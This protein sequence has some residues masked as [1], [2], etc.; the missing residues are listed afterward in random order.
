MKTRYI[1]RI[2]N[3][4][5]NL[6]QNTR[7]HLV[8]TVGNGYPM[9]CVS[10]TVCTLC[11][12]VIW[13]NHR[14]LFIWLYISIQKKNAYYWAKNVFVAETRTR[15]FHFQAHSSTKQYYTILNTNQH[16]RWPQERQ[17]LPTPFCLLDT[18]HH[19][20]AYITQQTVVYTADNSTP[21]LNIKQFY[22]NYTAAFE[23][24]KYLDELPRTLK[25]T[26]ILPAYVQSCVCLY[27]CAFV[28]I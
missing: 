11:V 3:I 25:F 26:F 12:T 28:C 18:T 24:A 8:W 17:E 23:F 4:K 21:R 9:N 13:I 2:T 14:Y 22:K 27:L 20:T 6:R 10:Y 1:R 5:A 15:Y 16:K 7:N 19:Q